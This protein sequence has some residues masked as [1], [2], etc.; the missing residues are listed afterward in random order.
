MVS[1]TLSRLCLLAGLL[2]LPGGCVFQ[3][4]HGSGAGE[5]AS[6][7]GGQALSN[8]YVSEV[9]TRVA[10]Q[11]RNELIFL[12]QG[13]P[14]NT[15]ARYRVDLRIVDTNR[16]F[17]AVEN[18]RDRTAG[19]VTVSAR[20]DLVDTADL[21]NIASGTRVATASYDRTPQSFANQRAVR[22]AEN[23]AAQAVAEK[24]RLALAAEL[25]R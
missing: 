1:S 5:Y 20:Y 24:L 17:A 11:V 19:S 4:L 22:D 3:P 9:D 2:L 16:R 10:Q 8:I 21:T 25:T 23:R 18:V 7:P 12:L 15:K 6:L 13:G 14:S